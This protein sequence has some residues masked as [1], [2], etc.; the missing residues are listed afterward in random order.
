MNADPK[1]TAE[2]EAKPDL[3]YAIHKGIRFANVK[4]LTRLGQTDPADDASVDA[5][6]GALAEHLEM[7]L[8]HLEHENKEIHTAIES[9]CPGGSA[10]AAEDHGEHEDSFEQ[11]RRL[12]EEVAAATT[13]RAA[14]LRRLYQR[15]AL[16]VAHDLEHMHEEETK[17]QPLVERHFSADE[18]TAIE[19][20][21][22][23]SIPPAKM[24]KFL[25][26]MLGGASRAERIAMITGME[27][28]MPAEVFGGM[29]ESVIGAPWKTGD[30]AALERAV[31]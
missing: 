17:L 16:F 31:C 4:M 14:K 8:S 27:L 1:I 23:Q 11:L 26:A 5:T 28:G 18:I 2:T 22:V 24:A 7:S 3:Y 6:L 21:I 12:A 15:F 10:H 20:R 30:W 13:D 19:Q 29:M 9:R 25:R